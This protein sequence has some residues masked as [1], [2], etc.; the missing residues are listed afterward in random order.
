MKKLI[1]IVLF[2]ILL[3]GCGQNNEGYVSISAEEAKELMDKSEN[4]IILDV[5]TKE[6]YDEVHIPDA[7]LIPDT[8]IADR[9][10]DEL[11]DKEQL[12]FVYCRS[13][14][15]SKKASAILSQMGYTNIK[16]FG[17]IKDWPYETE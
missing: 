10:E 4:Y 17:G 3:T 11:T 15:R 13:G 7:I 6:E 2:I 9:A 16:E 12:I 1:S 14:N 8:E 5:R